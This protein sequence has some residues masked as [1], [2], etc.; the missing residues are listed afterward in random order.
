MPGLPSTAAPQQLH[1]QPPPPPSIIFLVLLFSP[2]SP[3]SSTPYCFLIPPKLYSSACPSSPT[4]PLALGFALTDRLLTKP[5]HCPRPFFFS[6]PQ[7]LSQHVVRKLTSSPP[8]LPPIFA[9][10]VASHR[11]STDSSLRLSHV[12]MGVTGG[13]GQRQQL[14]NKLV[15]NGL[16]GTIGK[17]S[18]H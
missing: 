18:N 15:V 3:L 14:K 17:D 13:H 9:F 12:R 11:A 5:I 4:H 2:L 10:F 6:L 7:K 8:L 16:G 1:I